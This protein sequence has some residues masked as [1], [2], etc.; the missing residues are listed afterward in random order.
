MAEDEK[1]EGG[2]CSPDCKCQSCTFS[3]DMLPFV[4]TNVEP[5]DRFNSK[6]VQMDCGDRGIIGINVPRYLATNFHFNKDNMVPEGKKFVIV[7]CITGEL[8]CVSIYEG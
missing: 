2:G 4:A 7:P 8:A 1:E 6:S 5:F 3:E